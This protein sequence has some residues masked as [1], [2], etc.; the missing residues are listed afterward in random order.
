MPEDLVIKWLRCRVHRAM[1][2]LVAIPLQL[3]RGSNIMA[4]QIMQV[5]MPKKAVERAATG[6]QYDVVRVMPVGGAFFVPCNE[7]EDLNK[8]MRRVSSSCIRIAAEENIRLAFR[9]LDGTIA[10]ATFGEAACS[11]AEDGTQVDH[12]GV[13]VWRIAGEYN[14]RGPRKSADVGMAEIVL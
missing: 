6:S 14:H 4:F 11:V 5:A 9:S 1:L 13:G 3:N 7:G 2:R 10:V 8:C 12:A